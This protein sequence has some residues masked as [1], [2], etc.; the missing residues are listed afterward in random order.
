MP[1]TA[2]YGAAVAVQ[3][4]ADALTATAGVTAGANPEPG[5]ELA[6]APSASIEPA[7]P[8]AQFQR[9]GRCLTIAWRLRLVMGR[10]QQA[11]QLG[12]ALDAYQAAAPGLRAAGFDVGPLEA[13]A[14]ADI[15]GQ[16]YLVAAFPIYLTVKE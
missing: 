2:D 7:A 9:L 15:G 5:A 12:A 3:L 4:A 14:V 16:P 13:P 6:A 11:A 1:D 10:W 8:W